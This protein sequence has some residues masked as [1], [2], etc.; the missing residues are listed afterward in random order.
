MEK[1]YGK[2][3]REWPEDDRP[4]EKLLSRGPQ[5]LSDAELVAILLRTGNAGTAETAVDQAR[6]LLKTFGSLEGLS[7]AA[8]GQIQ[9]ISGIGPAKAAQLLAAVEMGRRLA[10]ARIQKGRAVEFAHQVAQHFRSRMRDLKQEIFC[11]MLLDS[12][13][14]LIKDMVVSRGALDFSIVHP[15]EAFVSAVQE[16]ASAVIFVHNHPGGNPAPSKNDMEITKRLVEAGR[17]LGI[18]VLDHV[19][20]AGDS[21]FSFMEEGLISAGRRAGEG[22]SRGSF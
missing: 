11:A 17:V 5:A 2:A 8:P 19:I 21:Y 7:R 14:R 13:H 9:K 12:S 3:I 20:L 10:G 6:K 16:S 4:R 15:R 18:P 22:E 1:R